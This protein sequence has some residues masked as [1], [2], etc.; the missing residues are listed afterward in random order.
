MSITAAKRKKKKKQN[1]DLKEKV[2]LDAERMIGMER[3][4]GVSISPDGTLAAFGVKKYDF[5]DK[6]I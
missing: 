3:V 2:L 6:K 5:D 1:E 4:G